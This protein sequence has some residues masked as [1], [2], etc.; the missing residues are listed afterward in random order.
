MNPIQLWFSDIVKDATCHSTR[1]QQLTAML[2]RKDRTIGE[3][4][5]FS[6]ATDP[7]FKILFFS[8]FKHARI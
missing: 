1:I 4:L 8:I 3:L 7:E 6:K 5:L 2:K